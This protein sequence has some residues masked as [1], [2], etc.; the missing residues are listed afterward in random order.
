MKKALI[1]HSTLPHIKFL[2]RI[3]NRRKLIP[4][5]LNNFML[6]YKGW[7]SI[8]HYLRPFI[9]NED[10]I[11]CKPFPST[12]RLLKSVS[13]LRNN[14][15]KDTRK[16]IKSETRTYFIVCFNSQRKYPSFTRAFLKNNLT[17]LFIIAIFWI[18]FCHLQPWCRNHHFTN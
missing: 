1:V 12:E 6:W 3:T 4:G 7:I 13:L 8:S 17:V 2:Q 10:E 18:Y 16:L 5:I 11:R 15:T 9:L 14:K